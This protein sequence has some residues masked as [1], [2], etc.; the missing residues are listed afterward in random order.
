M[1]YPSVIN[2][3][4]TNKGSVGFLVKIDISCALEMSMTPGSG[5]YKK[6]APEYFVDCY[7]TNAM[8]ISATTVETGDLVGLTVEGNVPAEYSGR[9]LT[10]DAVVIVPELF[11]RKPRN[12]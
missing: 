8:Y 5:T 1:I 12:V 7:T 2:E 10:S 3:T 4:A 11:K 9:L 6:A